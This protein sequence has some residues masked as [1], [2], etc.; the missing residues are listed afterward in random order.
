MKKKSMKW[1]KYRSTEYEDREH[2]IWYIGRVMGT[3]TI[4]G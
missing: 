4:N 2:S 3:N 1:K